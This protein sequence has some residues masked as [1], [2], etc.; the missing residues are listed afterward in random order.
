MKGCVFVFF[1]LSGIQFSFSQISFGLKSGVN[2]SKIIDENTDYKIKT[3]F[4]IGGF[5]NIKLAE[6][7]A[8]QPELL[9]SVQGAEAGNLETSA[10]AGNEIITVNY[11]D[12][13]TRLLYINLPLMVKYYVLKD[14]N[15]ECGPQIGFAVKNEI[16][17]KSEEFGVQTGN[18]DANVDL[19]INI[20]LEYRFYK[21]LGIQ[22]R[23]NKGL[24]NINRESSWGN[25]NSVISLGLSYLFN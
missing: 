25:K 23:Y 6:Q 4:Y 20:G 12:V 7:F 1:L 17:A 18:P 8:F 3:G 19:S 21:G 13:K 15:F 5:T 9:F 11:F 16:T 22:G 14:L 24:N 2:F 10:L